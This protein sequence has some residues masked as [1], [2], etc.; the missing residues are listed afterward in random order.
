MNK[1]IIALSALLIAAPAFAADVA[2]DTMLGKT[3]AEITGSLVKMGYEV[4]KTDTEDGKLEVYAIKDGKKLEIYVDAA[5]G[6]VTDV[7]SD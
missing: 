5:T 4:R 1:F 7:K 3:P 2:R 6:A